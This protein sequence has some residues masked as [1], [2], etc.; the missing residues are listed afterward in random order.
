M[1]YTIGFLIVFSTWLCHA[2]YIGISNADFR[3]HYHAQKESMWC[4][5]SS[6]EMVLSYE[7]IKL[8]Q[9]AIVVRAKG[10]IVDQG[11]S[12]TD[13]IKSVNG[14]FQNQ[15]GKNVVVSGQYVPGAPPST[16]LYNQLKAKKPVI[17]TYQASAFSGHAVVV[18]GIDAT[19]VGDNVLIS[20]I[21]IFD[22]FSYR[23]QPPQPII[24]PNGMFMGYQPPSLVQDDSLIT[25][26]LPISTWYTGV[27]LPGH[28]LVTAMILVDGSTE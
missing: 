1:K 10:F 9:E 14:V 8:P 11:G 6:A 5:A 18:T 7:G 25:Q 27:I 17:L 24:A 23:Q 19:V 26:V 16:V 2:E 22:P 12:P 4:W 28:G 15:D 13:I 3:S 21:H 20:K